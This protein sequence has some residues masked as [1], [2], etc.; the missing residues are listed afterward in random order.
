MEELLGVKVVTTISTR[1][2]G[3]SGLLD[4]LADLTDDIC[5]HVP[6]Q[7]GYGED[8]ENAVADVIKNI[9]EHFPKLLDIYPHKWIALKLIEMD[10]HMLKETQVDTNTVLSGEA[11][12]HLKLSYGEDLEGFISDMRYAK[13]SGLTREVL[14]KPS[15]VK[16]ELTKTID[17]VVLNKYLGLPIFVAAMWLMFKLTFD[18]STPFMDWIDA[19]TKG[20]LS[21]WGAAALAAA[22]APTWLI[23]LVTE[24]IIGG[25]G[26]VLVFVPIIAAMMLF[27]IDAA[28]CNRAYVRGSARR[29]YALYNLS[30][31]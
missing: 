12:K 22:S 17:A 10:R 14:F 8:L 7:L 28:G 11:F 5:S 26:F 25:A 6:R 23:S 30:G 9:R 13:A 21:R 20:P 3:V 15:M 31:G 16:T 2:A 29:A 19:V 1:K 4:A 18:V 27:I 24:G